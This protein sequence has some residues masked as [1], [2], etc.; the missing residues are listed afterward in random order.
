MMPALAATRPLA[1]RPAATLDGARSG[2]G[3][4][5]PISY[6]AVLAL[7]TEGQRFTWSD[8]DSM[9]YALGIGMGS[10]PLDAKE[11]PFVYENGLKAVPTMATIIA[12]NTRVLAQSGVNFA[13]VVHGEQ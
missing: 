5:V 11:L 8:R 13:M 10:D 2:E 6:P 3:P 4:H 9:L 1:H 7:K 12:F